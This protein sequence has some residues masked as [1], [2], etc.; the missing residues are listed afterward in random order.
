MVQLAGRQVRPDA[1]AK[2]LAGER[3]ESYEA[4]VKELAAF[5]DR[6]SAPNELN[7]FWPTSKSAV[8]LASLFSGD[9]RQV[10]DDADVA[11]RVRVKKI[12]LAELQKL[13]AFSMWLEELRKMDPV[14]PKDW[15]RTFAH[16]QFARLLSQLQSPHTK[17]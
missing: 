14:P 9:T 11:D 8:D 2:A 16:K 4:L 7:I 3:K 12:E 10:W 1:V 13:L 15:I 5:D 17:E 6:A